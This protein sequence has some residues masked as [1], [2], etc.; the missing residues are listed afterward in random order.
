MFWQACD[1]CAQLGFHHIETDNTRLQI[2]EA[3]ADRPSQF[4]EQMDKRQLTMLGFAQFAA[5]SDP[6]KKAQ[7]S[8]KTCEW[9]ISACSGWKVHYPSL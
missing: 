5:M 4:K 3:Y 7:V 8:S 6:A 2:V 1:E 9:P